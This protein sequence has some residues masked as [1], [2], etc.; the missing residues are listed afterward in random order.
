[1]KAEELFTCE[2]EILTHTDR[3]ILVKYKGEGA[4]IPKS[5]LEDVTGLPEKGN[6]EISVS[7]WLAKAK[8]WI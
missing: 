8:D 3:A 7:A 5:Q 6:A 2:V 4:W 1:M